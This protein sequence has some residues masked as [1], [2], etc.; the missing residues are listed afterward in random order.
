MLKLF[1][2]L[3]FVKIEIF[4]IRIIQTV[5]MILSLRTSYFFQI[6]SENFIKRFIYRRDTTISR[7]INI[8][9]TVINII[10]V[11]FCNQFLSRILQI[12]ISKSL[13]CIYCF[14]RTVNII[15]FVVILILL[16]LLLL[17]PK[18]RS[19]VKILLFFRKRLM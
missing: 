18:F 2:L 6:A 11:R 4:I 1:R 3:N 16:L 12:H 9:L 7:F 8:F 10:Y 13:A 5:L 17:R 19:F 15:F 14:K